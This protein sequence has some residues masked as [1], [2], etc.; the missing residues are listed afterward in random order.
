ML[1]STLNKTWPEAGALAPVRTALTRPAA[2]GL[3]R[4][5]PLV[6]RWGCGASAPANLSGDW[7][8]PARIGFGVVVL[9]FGAL[10]GWAALARIDSAVVASGTIVVESDR[11]AVQH[12]EGG[13]VRDVLVSPDTPVVEG[14]VLLRLEATQAKAQ[15]EIARSA[16]YSALAEQARLQAE[17]EGTDA[18]V[19]PASLAQALGD[20][21]AAR[22]AENQL[23][24]F[25]ERRSARS[26]D[27]SILEERVAQ[28][29]RQIE[30]VRSQGEAA[31]AQIES[32][33]EEHGK[34]KSLALK[35][36]VPVT[37]V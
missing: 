27:I 33:A 9:T 11:K 10:G 25:R 31:R 36:L 8:K 29:E 30:G 1:R 2:R 4:F 23:R 18:V 21:L 6:E 19:F 22:A 15:N 13:I 17:A 34:L 14:Q 7:R 26:N 24:L 5:A 16:V 32:I 12:L 3:G 20:P 37:R 28:A 35:G